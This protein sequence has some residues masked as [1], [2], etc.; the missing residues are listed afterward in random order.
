MPRSF[1]SPFQLSL[2]FTHPLIVLRYSD[3]SLLAF[4][5]ICAVL[6]AAKAIL[7]DDEKTIV[8]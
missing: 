6:T 5:F 1:D 3:H 4:K 8:I 7:G 2:S